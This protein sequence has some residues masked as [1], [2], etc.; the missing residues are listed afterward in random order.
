MLIRRLGVRIFLPLMNPSRVPSAR[1][2][3]CSSNQFAQIWILSSKSASFTRKNSTKP[4]SPSLESEDELFETSEEIFH[5]LVEQG[6]LHKR[7]YSAIDVLEFLTMFGVKSE[8]IYDIV[9]TKPYLIE[10]IPVANWQNLCEILQ[11][12]GFRKNRIFDMLCR[13]DRLLSMTRNEISDQ[14]SRLRGVFAKESSLLRLCCDSPAL[15]SMSTRELEE[16]LSQ[17]SVLF[18]K[19]D[20][21]TIIQQT[22]QILLTPIDDVRAKLQYV[23]EVLNVLE[24]SVHKSKMFAYDL[25]RIILRSEFLRMSGLYVR[26]DKRGNSPVLNASL[27]EMVDTPDEK[28]CGRVAQCEPEEFSAYC[29]MFRFYD[30]RSSDFVGDADAAL[31]S[32][33]EEDEDDEELD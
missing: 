28:F 30:P 16:Q 6:H 33:A 9:R 4:S 24:K 22:P 12:H 10:K 5:K 1:R 27:R 15:L 29:D 2:N 13:N 11:Q 8:N 31:E 21:D 17:L 25:E 23:L 20:L 18:I 19:R 26:P 32:D 7:S 14:I 3:S